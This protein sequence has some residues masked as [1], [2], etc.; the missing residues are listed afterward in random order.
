MKEMSQTSCGR[1]GF[2]KALALAPALPVWPDFVIADESDKKENTTISKPRSILLSKTGG[3]RA[4]AYAMSNKIARRNGQLLC[5]WIDSSRQN[6]W[7]LVHQTD[8][9]ILY[10]GP[11]GDPRSDNHSG[12]AIATDPDGTLH[13]LT[14]EHHRPFMHFRMPVSNS[15]PSWEPVE[16]GKAVGSVSTY[17]SLVCDCRG[18]LHLAYRHRALPHYLIDYCRRPKD[19]SWSKPRP[20]V[21]ASV[22][23]HTWLTNAIEAGPD[24]RL[25][26][27]LSNTRPLDG[28]ARYYGA[29]HIYSDDSGETWRQF[30]SAKPLELPVDTSQLKRIEADGMDP[31]RI[32]RNVGSWDNPPGP[33][34]S[35]YHQILLSNLAI[36]DAGRPWVIIH[37]LLTGDAQLYHARGNEWVSVALLPAVKKILPEF[38]ITHCGQ[39]SRHK[40]GMLDAVLMV[41]PE[42][43]LGW[44]PNETE[45]VRMHISPDGRI[46]GVWRVCELDANIPH[47]LPSIERWTWNAPIERPA[48]IYTRGLNAGG[49]AANRNSVNTEIRLQLPQNRD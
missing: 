46:C 24:G 27:V 23:N 14:G 36:D 48:L 15:R 37:N 44:G 9:N 2:L 19:G 18:T 47:W 29:S 22:E 20:L 42:K 17:P 11:V 28:R 16:D 7:A 25:H 12:A 30:G 3:D 1:R 39:L 6:R 38:H 33:L 32:E 41:A 10:Q 26:M 31:Q 49:Y 21:R 5:T 45:L 13:L 35:Y 34:N 8:G 4:T 40:D 43:S